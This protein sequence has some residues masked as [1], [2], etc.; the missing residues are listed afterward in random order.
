MSDRTFLN[1][2]FFEDRH[3]QLAEN[4]DAWCARNL[5][6]DHH[7]VDAACRDLVAKL[8]R[9]GWLKPTALDPDS[10]A[11][12]DVRTLCITRETLA[13]HDGLADFAF[14]MQGLGTGALSLFGTP[15]QQHWLAKTRAG[16]AISAFALS[17]PRSGSDVANM[18][19][20]ATRD[21][22]DYVLSGE[23]TWISNGGIADLYIVFARTGEAPGAKGISAFIVP[24]ETQGLSIAERLETIAPHPLARLSFD[25]A[26]VPA[27]SLIGKPG[28]GFR[29]AMSVLDVF[30]STVGAAA[31]GFARRAL[32]ESVKRAAA[33]KLFG[34]PMAELQMVQG[35]IADMA[36]DVDA[37]AL[38]V[39]RAAWTKDMGAARV[40][41][42]AAMAKLFA[43]DKA[44]EVIDKAVQLHGGDGVRK[45]HIVESLYREIRA[46]RIYEGASDV[47]KV[48]IARQI[49][50][51]A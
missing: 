42:E 18:E 1:W 22:S 35:H 46:L 45:G 33:R 13:R 14:A 2:P 30:R 24:A 23:K 32:D 12:L 28:D 5:P 25:N 19:M 21:G 8:G 17:E 20:T 11:P 29:I 7:D 47:Q 43:T 4:L 36:L 27:S 16:Q 6:V 9:D 48:V 31:L 34:A 37:A 15:D 10:P 41:R 39:Y 38:L 40:T 49:M 44:Q 26:R 3:R 51:A 50:G